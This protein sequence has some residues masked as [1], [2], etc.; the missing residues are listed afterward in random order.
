MHGLINRAIQC[1]VRD[2]YGQN[3]WIEVTQLADLGFTDFEA[4][5]H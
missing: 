5:L 1:F 4:M 3:R 2:S